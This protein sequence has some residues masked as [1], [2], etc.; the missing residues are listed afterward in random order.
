MVAGVSS[1]LFVL[2]EHHVALEQRQWCGCPR[3]TFQPLTRMAWFPKHLLFLSLPCPVNLINLSKGLMISCHLNSLL[4]SVC[5]WA[6]EE[7][8]QEALTLQGQMGR[9]A[10]EALGHSSPFSLCGFAF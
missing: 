2:V 6:R 3:A 5:M 4:S 1:S 8:S 7:T 9:G 10:C